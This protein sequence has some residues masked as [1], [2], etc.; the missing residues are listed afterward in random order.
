MQLNKD[1]KKIYQ[2]IVS[3]YDV[4]EQISK[5]QDYIEA[6][7]DLNNDS[8]QF[9]NAYISYL[10]EEYDESKNILHNLI[11]KDPENP[12]LLNSIGRVYFCL[13]DIQL[14]KTY[15]Q[16]SIDLDNE[17][18]IAYNN[19]A[20][21]YSEEENYEKA[22]EY[23]EKSI[24]LDNQ[25]LHP[26]QNIGRVLMILGENQKAIEAFEKVIQI[27]PNYHQSINSI[28][29]VLF[30]QQKYKEAIYYLQKANNLDP[31]NTYYLKCLIDIYTEMRKYELAKKNALLA[32]SIYEKKEYKYFI[33]EMKKTI[34]NLDEKIKSYSILN[35]PIE[36]ESEDK[37]VK[38][39]LKK[40]EDT[41]IS[42]KVTTNRN[43]S[44]K[45]LEESQTT[46]YN[47]NYIKV[48]RRWNSY[49]PIV[50]DN[51]HTS[52]GGGYFIKAAEMGIVVD[53]GFNFIDNFRGEG[54]SFSEITTIFISHAHNDH[55]TD[56]E[57]ILTLLHKYNENVK[58]NIK[59]ELGKS[60]NI[61][62]DQVPED[63]FN[64]LFNERKKIID[65]YITKSTFAKFM[66]IFNLCS[67][68][69][70]EIH[71]IEKE[72]TYKLGK[73]I[74]MYIID[75]KHFDIISDRD[76]VGFL[77][78]LT[79]SALIYTG[80]TGWSSNIEKQYKKVA[81][82]CSQ[83]KIILIAHIGGFKEHENNYIL[84]EYKNDREKQLYKNHLGRIG[85]TR[86]NEVV[87]PDL[88]II[89]E[90]GEEFKG[91]RIELTEIFQNSFNN[92]I[93]FLPADIGLLYNFDKNMIKAITDI[94]YEDNVLISDDV[95]ID[96]V[97]VCLLRKDYSLHYFSHVNKL[98]EA[99][100]IQF[101]R[102]DFDKKQG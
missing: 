55:T 92:E 7:E 47:N 32:L 93:K 52:K 74:N 91:Y 67:N 5:L 80:D 23:Y 31:E 56:L 17:S 101:I 94:N 43:K 72:K 21:I 84:P 99:D 62:L 60:L 73:D 83:K 54:H 76:S 19:L 78:L 77:L 86:I 36:D 59:N 65:L 30:N 85:L 41:G 66:G 11:L 16:K 18:A 82:K 95:N 9:I 71:I 79:N 38:K 50:A 89:S 42:L 15:L 1:Y 22:I 58:V 12:F 51:Y 49:T 70:Y 37:I 3:S 10:N 64:K 96:D 44:L 88:C 53:P 57:S 26:I 27:D 90:F 75:A 24:E 20:N 8:I 69:D 6:N 87:S 29:R 97:S 63:E 33:S 102:D 35:E 45:F 25:Y 48:L 28:G 34:Q 39:I 2:I 100:L 4:S 13:K 14:G 81:K 68:N 98:K 61:P 40:I 46:K